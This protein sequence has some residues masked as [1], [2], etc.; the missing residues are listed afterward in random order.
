MTVP[1]YIYPETMTRLAS[2]LVGLVA[3]I[4]RV[5]NRA[6][7]VRDVMDA[8]AQDGYAAV[9]KEYGYNGPTP[10]EAAERATAAYNLVVAANAA[11]Q[12]YALN[13]ITDKMG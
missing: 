9:A 13:A 7:N 10:E 5:Q 6:Q 4:Q 3:D 11:L 12:V 8:I 1:N 2:D